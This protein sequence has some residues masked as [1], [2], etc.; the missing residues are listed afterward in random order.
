M[1]TW[2]DR[3]Q[4]Y[5][6]DITQE[7]GMKENIIFG[8]LGAL[9]MMLGGAAID[10]A[11]SKFNVDKASVEDAAKDPNMVNK[12]KDVRARVK[13]VWDSEEINRTIMDIQADTERLI[14]EG[15]KGQQVKNPATKVQPQTQKEIKDKVKEPK[16][17]HSSTTVGK[18]L[19]DVIV[20]LEGTP[21]NVINSIGAAGTMQ[22]MKPTWEE[23]NKKGFGG[24]YPYS[25]YATNDRINRMFGEYYIDK[26]SSFLDQYKSEWKT[27]KASLVL[28]CYHGGIGNIQKAKFD[29]RIIKK[30]MPKTYSYM[31]RGAAL[32]GSRQKS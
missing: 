15:K 9:V 28:A 22:I 12:A 13:N 20:S 5:D 17:G 29:P 3:A 30:K 11:S 21:A 6:N 16:A 8:L 32:L 7:A 14:Q 10:K 19:F 26:I 23:I 31:S 2:Y 18:A 24:A 25:Q 4:S 1:K 27:D